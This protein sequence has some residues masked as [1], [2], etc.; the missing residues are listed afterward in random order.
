MALEL[1]A[2]VVFGVGAAG[3]AMLA[4]RLIPIIPRF[5]IP[6]AA[7]LAMIGFTIWSEYAW[8]A[9]QT[10]ALPPGVAVATS[11]AEP[12]PF[13]P[14]TFVKPF[15]DRFIAVDLEG[16]RRH[17]DTPEQVL[18]TLY[19]FER[20]TPTASAPMLVDCA[21]KRRA[22]IADGATFDGDGRIA[23]VTWGEVGAEDPLV[24]AVCA[25]G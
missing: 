7:G 17:P 25:S 8:F 20:H 14:W 24:S 5:A 13:R 6:A 21:G 12:S 18:V 4:R 16:A 1:I 11:I 19:M 9:R 2:A 15:T 10:A 23:D 3:V 22:D